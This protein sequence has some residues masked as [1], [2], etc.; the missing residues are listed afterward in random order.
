[1]QF[2]FLTYQFS[3]I[4]K[5]V[6]VVFITFLLACQPAVYEKTQ[7]SSINIIE[8]TIEHQQ[9]TVLISPYKEKL[10]KEMNEVL[11]LSAEEFPKEKGK[12]ETKLGNL[13]ADL[14]MEIAQKIHDGNIDVCMLNFGGLRTS[15]PKGEITRGKI[16][17]LM[18]FENELVVVTLSE[19][20]FLELMEYLKN[21]GGQPISGLSFD[22]TINIEN[23]IKNLFS[24]EGTSEINILT[25]DYLANGGD[26]MTFFLNPINY[27]K[28]GIKLRDAIIQY[29][30]EQHAQGKQLNGKIEGRIIYE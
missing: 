8:T 30:V 13:V 11:V 18:P 26:N 4:K 20:K 5:V 21:V 19:I 16:F 28:V 10:E 23:E 25:S 17:E 2:F 14:S 12:P 29:C 1:M 27:E 24:Q 15:L 7:D 22:F 3:A 9:A 6:A